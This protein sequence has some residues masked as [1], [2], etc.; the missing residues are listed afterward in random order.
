MDN[1][2]RL[3]LSTYEGDV[4]L[5]IGIQGILNKQS[6]DDLYVN[7]IHQ[8]FFQDGLQQWLAQGGLLPVPMLT[9]H[10]VVGSEEEQQAVS[11]ELLFIIQTEESTI[12]RLKRVVDIYSQINCEESYPG[13][14]LHLTE[15]GFKP[16]P[17]RQIVPEGK[18][19]NEDYLHLMSVTPSNEIASHLDL[20][21]LSVARRFLGNKYCNKFF[22]EWG[23]GRILS[24]EIP[25]FEKYASLMDTEEPGV[26]QEI[27][28]YLNRAEIIEPRK[29]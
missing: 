15:D 25:A 8:L 26:A 9:E 4:L 2:T 24:S 10:Y 20:N 27:R 3:V 14:Y 13:N 17:F 11:S 21:L 5:G 1:L 18:D 22:P 7:G 19:T 28:E 23:V 29:K 6:K 12:D 16:V